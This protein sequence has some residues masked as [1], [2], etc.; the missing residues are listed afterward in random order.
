MPLKEFSGQLD[1]PKLKEFTGKLD[2]ETSS[3]DASWTDNLRDVA[4]A[5]LKIGPTIVKGVAD[6]SNMLTGD[7]INLGVS[8]SMSKGMKAIDEVIGSDALNAQKA[9]INQ[10]LQDPNIG[11]TDLP[12]I[13]LQNPR[14][15]ADTAISTVGSMFLPAGA[16]AGTVKMLP[17]IAK[18]FPRMASVTPGAAATG[19]SVVTGAAQ[20][21]A[22]TFADTEGQAMGDRY[23]G[24]GISA[25]ASLVLGKLLGGGAEG[26]VARRLA[27]ESAV[28]GAA[29]IGK[30]AVKTGAKEFLQEGGEESSNYIGKQTARGE[31][32]DL[33]AMGKQGL[34][35]GM[36]G[37]GVGAGTDVATN[38]GDIGKGGIERQVA[39]AIDQAAQEVADR[40]TPQV[41]QQTVARIFDKM[42]QRQEPAPQPQP[43]PQ[44]LALGFDPAVRNPQPTMQVDPQGNASPM[45]SD[46]LA[47]IQSEVERMNNLGLTPDVQRAAAQ[48]AQSPEPAP[49]STPSDLI[50]R[51]LGSG[52]TPPQ[53]Q[54]D[55]MVL[56]NRNRATPSSVAQMT[57]IAANPDYGRLGFSRDFANGAP[58]VSGGTVPATQIGKSDVAVASDGRRIPVQYAVVEADQVLASNKSDGTANIDYGN[59]QVQ[60][61]RAIAGNG[62]I[63]GLQTAYGSAKADGYRKELTDDAL[64]GISKKVIKGMKQPVLVRIMPKDS[65]TADIGDVSNTVGNLSLSPVE[66]AKNDAQRV[67][68]DALQFAED[69]SI[70]PETVRQFVRAMPQ[71]EQGGLL[72]TNGQPTKQA[73]DRISAAV[74]SRA[75]GN[76]QLVRLYAQAQ[77]PEARNVLSALAQVAPKM[78]RLEGAGALDIRDVVTQAAEIAVNA[79]REGIAL[80]RAAQQLDMTAD[81]LVGEVLDLFVRNSRSVKPVVEALG[82][83]AD[84]AYTEANKPASDMFGEVPRASRGDII[85]Q[86]R[87]ENERRSQESLAQPA[88]REPVQEDAGGQAARPAGP[89][90][91]GSAQ[92][93]RP[94]E[95]SQAEGLTSYTPKDIEDRLSKLEQAEQERARLDREAEQ[96]AQADTQRDDFALTGSDRPA[97]V[98]ASRGQT[99][100]FSSQPASQDAQAPM[101]TPGMTP[102]QAVANAFIKEGSTESDG[103]EMAKRIQKM[104]DS[105]NKPITLWWNPED[106]ELAAQSFEPFDGNGVAIT[107]VEPTPDPRATAKPNGKIEDFGEKIGGARKDVWTSFQD[108]LG[109]VADD[110]IANQPL[111]KIWPQPDYQALLDGGASPWAVAFAHAAR[112]EIPANKPRQSWKLKQWADQVRLLRETT[113]KLMDGR[114]D[115]ERAKQLMTQFTSKG[116]RDVAG[117]VELY[118][119][120]GHRQSLSGVRLSSGEYSIHNGIEY[121]P[122][123]VIWSVEKEAAATAF[124]NWPRQLATGFTKEEA[125][126]AFKERYDSLDINPAAKKKET[127]FE[128]YSRRDSKGYWVGKKVGRNPIFLAGP[129]DNIKAARD[130]RFNNQAELV[131]KL[132]KSKEI[133]RERRDSNEPRVGEDMRNGQDVTPQMFGETFGFRGVEFGNWVEQGRR[134]KD[135]NDAFDALMDMAA[136][137]GVPPKALSLNG[138]LGLAFGARGGGGVNPAAAHYEPGKV[139]IN[140]TKKSGAGSLGHEWWHALDN[141]FSRM[142]AKGD[143]M[144]TDALDVSLASRGSNFVHQGAV[145]KEMIEAFGS[146]MKSIRETAIKARSAK[147][148]AKRSKE[149]WTTDPEM[150]ARAFESYL[151]SKLQDQDASNDY[152]A[153]IVSP[154][155]WKA[156]EAIGF[157]LD[158]SYPYPTAG[159]IPAIRAGFDKFFETIESRETDKGV[160]LYEPNAQYGQASPDQMRE[161]AQSEYDAVVAKYKNTDKWM[162][163]PNGNRTNLT[164][165]QWVQVRTPAFKAWF[166]DWEKFAGNQGGVWNDASQE[167]SKVVDANGEPLVV[168]HGTD[169]GGFT[170][171]YDTGGEMRGDLG[172]FTTSNRSMAATYVKRGRAKDI[173]FGPITE[174]DFNDARPADGTS[175][176]YASFLNIRNANESDFEGANWSGERF[177]Q[178]VL[179][180][181][182]EQVFLSDGRGYFTDEELDDAIEQAG[183]PRPS[184]EPAPDHGETTDSVVRDARRYKNDGAI[185][186]NVTDDGGG[187]GSYY[188]EPSDVFVAFDSSQVKSADQNLGTFGIDSDNILLDGGQAYNADARKRTYTDDRQLQLF[189]DNG[190][191]ASQA[192]PAGE[193]AQRSAV[194]AVDDLRST[195]AIL[196]LALSRDFAARQ[197]VSLVGQKVSSSEDLAILAQV[198]RDPRFETFRVVF[199]NDAGRVVSQVG[200]TSRLPASTSAIMGNDIDAYLADLSAAARNR[201]ASKFYMLHN[202]P[203]GIAMPSRADIV[204][205]EAFAQKM[206]GLTFVSHVV[207]DTNEYSTINRVGKFETHQKD[208]GQPAPMT[209]DEWGNTAISSPADV[210]AM[211]KKLQVDKN[212]VTLISLTNQLKVKGITTIP[213]AAIGTDKAA[214]RRAVSKAVMKLEGA[215]VVAV[216]RDMDTLKRM[217][218]IVT[219]G[220][221]VNDDGVVSSLAQLGLAGGDLF[222]NQRRVRVSPDT[223]P[224]FSYLRA[225]EKQPGIKAAEPGKAYGVQPAPWTVPE[226]GAGDAFIRAIQN[227]KIDVKRVRDAIAERYGKVAESKDAYLGEELYHGRVAARVSRIYDEQV[228]PLL[229]KIAV[230]GKNVGVT[231]DDVNLYLH[232]RHA[233]ERN[234]AMKAINPGMQDN[235]A[236][237]GMSDQEAAKVL[238]DF[239]AAGKDKA[240]SLI[241]ADV[242]QLLADTRTN[243]VADGL[244]DAGV[245]AAW[246]AAYKH[247]VPLQRDIKSTGTPKGMGFSIRGPESK[248]AVG[249]NREVV[250]ILANIVAQAETGAIRAEKA[251]VGRTLLA[252]A[253]QYPNPDFWKVDVPPTKPRIDKDT[254][255]VIRSAVDPLYQ[256]ADNVVMVKHYGQEHF[257]VFSKDSERAMAMAHA[258]KNLDIAPMNKILE[259]ANKGTRF[260]ASLLTQRN[261]MFWLTNFARDIQ[262]ALVNLEGTDAEGLQ[263]EAMGNLPKAFKGMH[264][265]VRGQGTGQWARYAREFHEAGGTTG[266]MQVFENSDK[267][268]ADLEKEVARMQQGKS[269]PRRLARLALE[270][271]DDYNDI[272][273][274]A[275]RLSV[276]QAARDANVSTAKAASIAKNITVNFNRKGNLT[277]PINSLYMFFNASVQGTARLA[278]A[279]VTSRKAQALVGGIA[280]MGFVLDALN[281]MAAGDDDETKRNRYD[282]IPEFEK[283]RN[284]I[285]MNPMRPGEYVKV[286]L[287]LGPHVFHN[288]GRLLSDAIFRKNPRNASEYGWSIAGVFLD[289]F[290]PLGTSPSLGQLIAPSV[291][292][293]AVQLAE[294]KSFTG[295]PVY[296]SADRGFG[297]T[298]PKPAYTR[299]FESTPEVWVG[300]SKL[301][302]D[303]TGGDKV[304]PGAIDISP[305]I[306]KHVFYTMTGGPGRTLDQAI[307]STQASARGKDVSVNR[308]PLASR[309]YGANDDSQ[310]ER[311]YYDDR[312]RVLDAKQTFDYYV[313]NGRTEEARKVAAE[314]GDGNPAKGRKKM[315]EFSAAEKSVRK[316]NGSIRQELAR[317]DD[318]EA[319]AEQLRALRQRRVRVMSDALDNE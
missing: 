91:A 117:R 13:V 111:S 292:D 208:F 95:D 24:A 141:Y 2:G 60:A 306:L 9:N 100:I 32:I 112:D 298:D 121:K 159:E 61:I 68:L 188:G 120:V 192:G 72:D 3:P 299:H 285:F 305:D 297:N 48:R 156:A 296:K 197:R 106:G 268:M 280:V 196:G 151:I 150:S 42:P 49:V 33:N 232:A 144:M 291:F 279:M 170:R 155:T 94:A 225:F 176:I 194:A 204:L 96:K 273:E 115:V 16:A 260:L 282:L 302:N 230:A 272:I 189:L 76:D 209:F 128:I 270:F 233:P 77:D 182:D 262:G 133:P 132:E 139:V 101:P 224:E 318:G 202:H 114:L 90:D 237:S 198:Y 249:S 278:Q 252:M 154:E 20:N 93:S 219:D 27:G 313:K 85:N 75:Y 211:A 21:A 303:A 238:A 88:G 287:P 243:L 92:A 312:K 140:L 12:G 231:I 300:A 157:E 34:Y 180:R 137:I 304:K 210:M 41:I 195:E 135:L 259:V 69:G 289:A 102:A 143:G 251:V 131:A 149:Y 205:T 164:E 31:D 26:V 319:T 253:K 84:M 311:A 10:A 23:Q 98:A 178:N 87:P 86:L 73:V 40:Q 281:R 254:G 222:P 142:R 56:Q 103:K 1:Q 288:A 70:T 283:S 81:P 163:A 184:I 66:Q 234:A 244:E 310:R 104:A 129:F 64:H 221:H 25:A 275:V 109:A 181:D 59:D 203:S 118:M 78:A 215:R 107:T 28:R 148:D 116:M 79:R 227:N 242:D 293:P 261:P 62:R 171:F 314:L 263:R 308:V 290:S 191:D 110:D 269:D 122:A 248:R 63:A 294:N 274:N 223:S 277:P 17:T 147:L 240:L 317:D 175:G 160:M 38:V 80:A 29:E 258:M 265:I 245:V 267:R 166:G 36:I 126:K 15:A 200:L 113:M 169:T 11:I 83:A 51:L 213:Q 218:S 185:I 146:V 172:I 295:A 119:L 264:A 228:E 89:Q 183:V 35:G 199:T 74:F 57:S 6:L 22:E 214:I 250:N 54:A 55:G 153:N 14:A 125:L 229:K 145:R 174:D 255:L 212:A 286:P 45:P 136:I 158:D 239:K 161:Q 4:A 162:R 316:I 220:I 307:D 44:P 46:Q 201:G 123:K 124:S 82:A 18:F 247:Y 50:Q 43:D 226:P 236:L 30:S 187:G 276:F 241:A 284:W 217:G 206:P 152:L 108:D 138:E 65:L 271:V 19:A 177:G 53:P 190:P 8:K 47:A 301:L 71:S 235:D 105:L 179:M 7:T 246:E 173:D 52:W 168:Y 99:E 186:R 58:V 97:D 134:Q 266:Y 315:L 127:S 256:T 309:F 37:L 67:S 193:A 257:I 167:V 216:S 5:G 39:R 165:R 130:Y 207:I